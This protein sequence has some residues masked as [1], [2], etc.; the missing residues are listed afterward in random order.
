M[1]FRLLFI[2]LYILQNI[3]CANGQYVQSMPPKDSCVSTSITFLCPNNYVPIIRSA[4]YG[5]SS[6][7]GS[8]SYTPGDCVA[9]AMNI[10]VCPDD[11]VD[12]SIYVTARKLS[13]CNDQVASYLRAEF[14]CVPILMTDSA[15]TYYVCQDGTDITS[16]HGIIESPGYPTQFQTTTTDCFR[17]I[18]V[19]DNKTIRLW[20]TDLYI[21]SAVTNCSADHLFVLDSIQ[22]YRHCG[23]IRL[24]YPELCSP[25]ILIQYLV[26]TDIKTY[27]GL[28]MYFEIVDRAPNDFCPNGTVTPVPV[29]TT[30]IVPDTTTAPPAY[31]ILGIASPIRSFQLCAGK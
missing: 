6:V 15:K 27:R 17:A 4:F 29:T 20:L 26:T 2:T 13:Q 30:P 18:H 31:A 1:M 9:D 21:G 3:F 7:V 28:R 8:C 12:C 23:F 10:M 16:D 22:T 24:A 25:T 14:E 11:S 19:P 5:I